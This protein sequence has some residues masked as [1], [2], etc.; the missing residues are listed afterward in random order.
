[1]SQHCGHTF[2]NAVVADIS[3]QPGNLSNRMIN[4]KN[5]KIPNQGGMPLT[6][7]SPHGL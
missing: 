6:Q 3:S 4:L 5:F 2:V 7:G 1:M